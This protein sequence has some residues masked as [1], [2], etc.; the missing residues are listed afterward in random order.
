MNGFSDEIDVYY[1][2]RKEACEKCMEGNWLLLFFFLASFLPFTAFVCAW[3]V[4]KHVYEPHLKYL[5]SLPEPVDEEEK[6]P[7]YEEK[8][9]LE[10]AEPSARDDDSDLDMNNCKVEDSTPDG[11]VIMQYNKKNEGFDYWS[12]KK[13]IEYKYL[14]TVAR[15]YV[16]EFRCSELY[17]DREQ[18]IKDQ[19][20]K[21]EEEKK[22][23]EEKEKMSAEDKEQEDSDDDVF[24]K[25][26]PKAKMVSKKPGMKAAI[27]ANK[28]RYKGKIKEFIKNR[29]K[30]KAVKLSPKKKIGFNDWKN[31]LISK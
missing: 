28:Y 22:M 29:E 5:N 11:D 3:L 27:R 4:A 18:D 6:E 15:K 1:A 13:N 24:A 16:T 8:Y 23:A 7:L 21:E 2:M 12:D 20:E 19:V 10:E 9:P 30:D 26:K 14:E 25:L 17:I 31:M